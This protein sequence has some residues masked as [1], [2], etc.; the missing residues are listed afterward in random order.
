MFKNIKNIPSD[1]STTVSAPTVSVSGE[2]W[3]VHRGAVYTLHEQPLRPGRPIEPHIADRSPPPP[4]GT[5][6]ESDDRD[7]ELVTY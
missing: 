7:W 1:P 3:V 2:L 6:E 5:A 4:D